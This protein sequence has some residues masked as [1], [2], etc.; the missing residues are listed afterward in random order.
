[1]G[2]WRCD[3]VRFGRPEHVMIR[4]KREFNGCQQEP[5][6]KVFPWPIACYEIRTGTKEFLTDHQRWYIRFTD[7]LLAALTG[8][9]R[10]Q[11]FHTLIEKEVI[12]LIVNL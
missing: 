1:M 8:G 9:A 11:P 3:L 7:T 4:T 2:D 6:A 12:P 5:D 10:Q